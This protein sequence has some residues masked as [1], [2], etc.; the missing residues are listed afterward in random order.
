MRHRALSSIVK[1][2]SQPQARLLE[3]T[4]APHVHHSCP[5][6]ALNHKRCGCLIEILS[7]HPNSRVAGTEGS[8]LQERS[9]QFAERGFAIVDLLDSAYGLLSQSEESVCSNMRGLLPRKRRRVRFTRCSRIIITTCKE[10]RPR[11]GIWR[12]RLVPLAFKRFPT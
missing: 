5:G 9:P 1:P 4:P 7:G 2:E 11:R 10:V 6:A 8:D 12:R 3:Q